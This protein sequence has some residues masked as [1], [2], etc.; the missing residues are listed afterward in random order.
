MNLSPH[1]T[2]AEMIATSVRGVSNIPLP[3]H[4]DNLR[5]LCAELLEPMR[6]QFGPLFTT[7][8]FRSLAVN[9]RIGGS[10]TSMHMEGCAWDGVPLDSKV[11]WREV[12]SFVLFNPALPVD[13]VIYEFGRW[14][15]I[16]T[17]PHGESCRREAL[18][19]FGKKYEP[20]NPDDPRVGR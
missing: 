6:K 13:Q 11:A 19:I 1:F 10:K 3:D 15:H 9:R 17:R 16:G 8:G 18:M 7:S 14:I 2:M 4:L 5:F 20:W 12:I